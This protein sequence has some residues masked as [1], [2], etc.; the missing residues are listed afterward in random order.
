MLRS[1]FWRRLRVSLDLMNNMMRF[2]PA[3]LALV[4]ALGTPVLCVL[5]TL[6]FGEL[7]WPQRVGAVYVGAAVFMQGFL[8]ADPDRFSRKLSDGN[9]LAA[10]FNQSSFSVAVFGTLFAAFG[11]LFPAGFYYGVAMCLA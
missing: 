7:C 8:G 5:F 3:L 1:A 6:M 10:H 4:L 2:Y 9:T 11:D